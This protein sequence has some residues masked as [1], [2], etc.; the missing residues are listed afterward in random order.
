M[1][2]EYVRL[3]A[4]E[5]VYGETNLL[6]SEV[7]LLTTVQRYQEFKALKKEE[8]FLKIELKR[9]ISEMR[10]FLSA[11]AKILP[12]S[13]SGEEPQ[14]MT[15]EIK[16]V[17]GKA[18]KEKPAAREIKETLKK[19]STETELEEIRKRLARLQ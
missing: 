5:L 14:K 10:E 17:A 1:S 16:F 19:P 7:A 18:K 13:R 12:E 8:L 6:Q 4:P 2:A 15:K 11:L 9:K 3:T